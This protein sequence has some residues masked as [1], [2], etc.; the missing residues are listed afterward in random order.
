VTLRIALLSHDFTN[1]IGPRE[2]QVS[3]VAAGVRAL[4]HEP[5][6]LASHAS[7]SRSSIEDGITVLRV[8]SIAE[9]WLR[10]RGF[11]G[12]LTQLPLTVRVLMRGDF[13]LA[14]AFSAV[15]A[16]A[17]LRWKRATGAPVVFTCMEALSRS[18][19]ADRRLR[20]LL[21]SGAIEDSDA[22]ITPSESVREAL[23][24]WMAADASVIAPSDG[25]NHL[26]LYEKL[27]R[28]GA[29]RQGRC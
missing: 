5:V 15:D 17:A 9:G 12:P 7:F 16:A 22:V 3:T 2:A 19:L 24:R 23:L 8:A 6:I 13:D 1:P 29:P 28:E 25:V 11:T 26:A 21:L 10:R 27:L 4:G 18:R 20:L 14:H